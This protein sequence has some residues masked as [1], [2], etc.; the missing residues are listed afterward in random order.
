MS[1]PRN[2]PSEHHIKLSYTFIVAREA[3]QEVSAYRVGA[4]SM[5]VLT[6]LIPLSTLA[7]DYRGTVVHWHNVLDAIQ[8][9]CFRCISM[10]RR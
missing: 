2:T 9:P 6:V 5:D 3:K 10:C 7:A 8:R 1:A 4:L